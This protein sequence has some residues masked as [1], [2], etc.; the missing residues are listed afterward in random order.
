MNSSEQRERR[1]AAECIWYVLATIAGEP[2][3]LGHIGP[4]TDQNQYYWNGLMNDRL[5]TIGGLGMTRLKL[6]HDLPT[7]TPQ[8][9]QT[10]RTALDTRGFAG[11][12][13]PHVNSPIDF[14]HVDFPDFVCFK[15]FVFV[16]LTTFDGARFPGL[17]HLFLGTAFASGVTFNGAG[18][19]GKFIGMQAQFSER[20]CFIGATFHQTATFSHCLFRGNTEFVGARFIGAARFNQC[21]FGLDARFADAVFE[22][23]ADFRSARFEGPTH[24]QRTDFKSFVPGFFDAMLH[25]YTEWHDAK[26]PQT[27]AEPDEARDQIQRYQRL[28]RLMNGL[29]KPYDQHFF[30]RKELHV[31]RRIERWNLVLWMNPVFWMNLVY[32]GICDYGYGLG[33]VVVLWLVHMTLGAV[34]LCASRVGTLTDEKTLW[35]ATHEAFSDFHVAFALSFGNAHGPL[36][37]N[38]SFFEDALKDWP[39]YGVVGPVQTVLGVIILFF[40]L[41]TIRNRFRMR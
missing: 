9:R 10:I 21:E 13:I 14:L 8:D 29:E 25:E 5:P 40:L 15:E 19:Y 39:W 41:L 30:F 34:A 32:E 2:H 1:P 23:Q 16:G 7:L 4:M 37:L 28:A 24:F 27:P 18:F 12:D 17:I 33:R 35:R 26:W 22:N 20:A 36:G 6:N 3:H 11:V 38:R 31:Q